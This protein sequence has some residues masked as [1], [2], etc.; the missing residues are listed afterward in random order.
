MKHAFIW[1]SFKVLAS[2]LASTVLPSPWSMYYT[3]SMLL[4]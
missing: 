1:I 3:T 4:T 2:K